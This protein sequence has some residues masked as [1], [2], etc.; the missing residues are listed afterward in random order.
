MLAIAIHGSQFLYRL[1]MD[2]KKVIIIT[3]ANCGIGL[4]TA[5]GLCEL[6]HDVVISVRDAAK[7][8][9]TIS[10]IKAKVSDAQVMY[11]TMEMSDPQSIRGFV[12]QFRST[13]KKLHVL[14]NNAGL[15]KPYYDP[16]RFIAREDESLE[17]S[18]TVNCM[19]PFLLTNLL[20]DMLKEAG[21]ETEPTRIVNVSSSLTVAKRAAKESGFFIEDIMLK[22]EGHY[23]NGMQSYRNSKLALNLWTAE[24]A[25]KLHGSHVIANTVCPGFI[26]STNLPR[27]STTSFSGLVSGFYPY[28]I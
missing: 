21:T 20:L 12:E 7:G 26:P 6:G 9:A 10:E 4:E 27:D 13:G 22:E 28:F 24:L 2:G 5:I 25:Q 15:F 3:G 14:I 8:E 16:T 23:K 11:F 17:I 18:M 19:G 1:N